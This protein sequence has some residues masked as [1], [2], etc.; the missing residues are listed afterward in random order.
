[1]SKSLDVRTR[2]LAAMLSGLSCRQPAI[3]FGVSAPSAIRRRTMERV[4]GDAKPKAV[5]A[6]PALDAP[7]PSCGRPF[8]RWSMRP[9]TSCSKSSGRRWP[10]DAYGKL[11]RA[12]ALLSPPQDHAQKRPRTARAGSPGHRETPRAWFNGQL[13]SRSRPPC[14]Q[15]RNARP[16]PTSAAGT[17][18]RR[19]GQRLRVGVPYVHSKTTTFVAGLH[20][21]GIVAPV[22]LDGS[23]NGS[24]FE[25]PSADPD[26]SIS[27][28]RDLF[29]VV[30]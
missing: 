30:G 9:R 4:Q 27:S 6:R 16:R 24:A 7:G 12:V 8:A 20:L 11:R 26:L 18:G 15:H 28:R 23:T 19:N 29:G 3:R 13:E 2:V 10:R 5:V 25:R 21:N 14:V 22:V 17:D 1:M